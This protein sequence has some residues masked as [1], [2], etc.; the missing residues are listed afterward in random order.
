MTKL[1]LPLSA[2]LVTNGDFSNGTTGW[3]ITD[4]S[5]TV[6]NGAATILGNSG[7]WWNI[8]NYITNRFYIL[9]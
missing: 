6:T 7:K 3:I 5:A 8:S 9:C 2:E 1:I 4:G